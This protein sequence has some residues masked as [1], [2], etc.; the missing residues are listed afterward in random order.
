MSFT[1]KIIFT[2]LRPL[3]RLR[4]GMTLGAQ[5]MVLDQQGRVLLVRHGYRPGW[6]FPGGGVEWLESTAEALARELYEETGIELTGA[7]EL[8]G[9][10]T[11][12]TKFKGDH[13]AVYIVK[14]WR[15]KTV[16]KPNAE[17]RQ[18]EFFSP[19]ALPEDVA[20]AVIKRL[21]EV[22]RGTAPAQSWV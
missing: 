10:F 11:N 2:V 22:R 15:Q 21:D 7:A 8:H 5:A 13:I 12:F 3:W 20:P 4:R 17:I 9:I 14:E 16:H 18:T 19:D 1:S 6:H